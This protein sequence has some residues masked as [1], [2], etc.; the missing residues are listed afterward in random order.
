MPQIHAHFIALLLASL[1]DN[2]IGADL[3]CF[4]EAEC[5]DGQYLGVRSQKFLYL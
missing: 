1:L 2:S 4:V 5:K 3:Q